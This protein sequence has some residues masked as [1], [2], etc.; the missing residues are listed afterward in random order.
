M[1][2]AAKCYVNCYDNCYDFQDSH[3]DR[4]MATRML[5]FL[6]ENCHHDTRRVLRNNLDVIKTLVEVWKTRIDV[7]IRYEMKT[8]CMREIRIE[9]KDEGRILTQEYLRVFEK[10]GTGHDNMNLLCDKQQQPRKS[11]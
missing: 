9:N 4:G 5:E 1:E 8:F 10:L 6:M 2:I 7:P 11:V 3:S